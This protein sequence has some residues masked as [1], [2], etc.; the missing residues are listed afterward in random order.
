MNPKDLKEGLV[1]TY[2][3]KGESPSN[4]KRNECGVVTSWNDRFVFVRYGED[5]ASKATSIEDLLEGD[6]TKPSEPPNDIETF[7]KAFSLMKTER[8]IS[9]HQI[10]RANTPYSD[11]TAELSS[12][13]NAY[14][15]CLKLIK[16]LLP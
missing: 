9:Y 15:G 12:E 1:V 16:D 8:L 14:Y 13:I 2:V 7:G 6:H 5:S 11:E 3:P 4:Y 10:A